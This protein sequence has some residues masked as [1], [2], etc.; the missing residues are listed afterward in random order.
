MGAPPRVICWRQY[1]VSGLAPE[2][3]K[4]GWW[5]ARF[6]TYCFADYTA[7]IIDLLALVTRVGVETQR[8]TDAKKTAAR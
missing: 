7:R 2:P 4:R 1:V 6:K 8:I 5:A 3:W